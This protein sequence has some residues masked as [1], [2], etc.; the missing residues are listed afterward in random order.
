MTAERRDTDVRDPI[1]AIG[2]ALT[3]AFLGGMAGYYLLRI[4]H[5]ASGYR[6]VSSRHDDIA[7][8]WLALADTAVAALCGMVLLSRCGWLLGRRRGPSPWDLWLLEPALMLA[9]LIY[10]A[11]VK[12]M[13]FWPVGIVLAGI[14]YS[15]VHRALG[16]RKGT[17]RP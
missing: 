6:Y 7:G 9:Y 8:A 1:P 13:P 11:N 5:I 4:R 2:L 12:N 15:L 10:V 16:A 17:V 14:A 3:G